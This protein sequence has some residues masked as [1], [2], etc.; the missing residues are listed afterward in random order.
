M[1]QRDDIVDLVTDQH[2]R[3]E[4]ML[5]EIKHS[6]G[7]S[8]GEQFQSLVAFLDPHEKAEQQVIYPV[9]RRLG[10]QGQRVVDARV[11]EEQAA[12]EAIAKLTTLDPAG[13]EF[14]KAFEKFS[15]DVH[16]HAESE[17]D[18]VFGLL[19]K[20]VSDGDRRSMAEQFAQVQHTATSA[21]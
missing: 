3:V 18:E 21:R 1:D 20:S 13:D 11:A 4:R 6:P 5:D 19:R 8:R 15:K 12:T 2:H 9:L 7:A 14:A 16:A 10:E 17:E